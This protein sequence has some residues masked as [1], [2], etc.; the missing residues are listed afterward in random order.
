MV[1]KILEL[2]KKKSK[3]LVKFFNENVLFITS[4]IESY[5]SLY[6]ITDQ[7]KFVV[8]LQV[9]MDI[10]FYQGRRPRHFCGGTIITEKLVLTAAHCFYPVEINKDTILVQVTDK[11]LSNGDEELCSSFEFCASFDS[12]SYYNVDEILEHNHNDIAFVKVKSAF[13]GVKN[14]AK[15]PP[16]PATIIGMNRDDS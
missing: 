1:F 7:W 10:S 8:S 12:S 14:M 15:L 16:H 9:W 5:L 4:K 3:I 13:K 2:K 6:F 11:I